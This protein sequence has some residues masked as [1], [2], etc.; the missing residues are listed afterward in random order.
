M[1]P[2][3]EPTRMRGPRGTRVGDVIVAERSRWLIVALD[4]H[5]REA[6]ARLIGG[7]AVIHRF[8]ARAIAAVERAQSK[9]PP[10]A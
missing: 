3:T 4:P 6:V 1:T 8:R 9:V 2:T 5:R 7:S 10:C